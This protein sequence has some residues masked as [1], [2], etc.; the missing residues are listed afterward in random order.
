M[1]IVVIVGPTIALRSCEESVTQNVAGDYPRTT[2]VNRSSPGM[3][4]AE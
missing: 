4:Q 3:E 1:T 2:K